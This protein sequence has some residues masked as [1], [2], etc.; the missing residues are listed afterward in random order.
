MVT[1]FPVLQLPMAPLKAEQAGLQPRAMSIELEL[2]QK[3]Y[4]MSRIRL[5]S[6]SAMLP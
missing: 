2:T 1:T 5:T 4:D 6:H 3:R